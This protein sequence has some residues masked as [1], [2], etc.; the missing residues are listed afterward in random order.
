MAPNP[1]GTVLPWVDVL[2]IE[3]TDGKLVAVLFCHAAHPVIVHAAS[4]L[5]SADYPGFA[6]KT[7]Q[8][9]HGREAVYLFAQGCGGNINAFPLQ[10]GID[11]AIAA[12]R[13][14]GQAVSRALNAK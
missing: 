6:V 1:R 11:A 10:G 4:T 2:A 5:I 9:L 3:Q 7:L 14:L 12:G 13:D 8:K